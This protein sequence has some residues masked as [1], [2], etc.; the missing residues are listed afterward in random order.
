MVVSLHSFARKL[1]VALRNLSFIL[2][3]VASCAAIALAISS[4]WLSAL[5]YFRGH[6]SAELNPG[7]LM[8]LATEGRHDWQF[9]AVPHE[10]RFAFPSWGMH[11]LAAKSWD[12]IITCLR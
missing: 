7:R 9:S 4:V 2:F 11:Q 10:F 6:W 12:V 8:L 3:T 1:V 5:V